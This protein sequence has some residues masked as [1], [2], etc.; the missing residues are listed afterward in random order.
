MND[1]VK[2]VMLNE[3][4]WEANNLHIDELSEA[5]KERNS[6]FNGAIESYKLLLSLP[7][8]KTQ[9]NLIPFLHIDLKDKKEDIVPTILSEEFIHEEINEY[10]PPDLH[11]CSREYYND[12]YSKLDVCK[13]DLTLDNLQFKFLFRTYYDHTE[14]MYAREIYVF[15]E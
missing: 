13:L 11:F 4:A 8:V 6:W 5:Y 10:T 1:W 7:I 14:M 3:I 12:F 15:N 9:H 2:S